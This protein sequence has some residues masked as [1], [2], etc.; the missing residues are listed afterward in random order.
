MNQT[1]LEPAMETVLR[2]HL[3]FL[4]S[5]QPLGLDAPL[6]EL[7]LDSMQAVELVFDLE[8]ELGVVFPDEAMT[9]ETFATPRSL[10]AAIAA[11]WAANSGSAS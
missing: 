2:K 7:G 10:L 3:S 9:A 6:R 11:T 8:D 4:A 1:A 5:D